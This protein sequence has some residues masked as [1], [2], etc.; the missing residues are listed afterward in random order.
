MNNKRHLLAAT[1]A[2]SLSLTGC[3]G[4]PGERSVG[5]DEREDIGTATLA[6]AKAPTDARCLRVE[7]RAPARSVTRLIDLTPGQASTFRMEGLPTGSVSVKGDA[8]N[9]A[10]QA[11]F[12]NSIPSWYSEPVTANIKVV[13]VVHL[14][15]EMIRNGR[16]SVGVDFDPENGPG[17]ENPAAELPGVGS[18]RPSFLLPTA[19][20]VQSRAILTV[21]D[22]SNLKPDGTPYRMV[23]L[24]DGLG[25]FDNGDGTFTLLANHEAGAT[26]GI[27]RA[28]GAAGSFVSAWIVRKSDLAVLNGKD[29]MTQHVMWSATTS[30]YGA[31]STGVAFSRFCSADLPDLSAFYDAVSGLGY[32]GRIFTN[33]EESG[34][35]GRAM[36]HLLNG[37]S[38]EVPRL[39]KYSFENA[40]ANP[41]TGAKTVVVGLD[42]SGNGQIYVYAGDKTNVGSPV[43]MAGLTNG[44]L[45]GL[46]VSG[47]ALENAATGIPSGTAFT[48]ANLGNVENTTGAALET[49]SVAAGATGFQRP[50]DGAWDPNNPN[51]FYFVTTASFTGNSRLWRLRFVDA[52]SPAL[53]GKI[54]MLLDGSEG[55]KM[56]DNIGIDRRG[57][58]IAQEDTGGQD[59]LGKVFRYDI[60]SDTLTTILQHDPALFTPGAPGFLTRDE[61]ASGVIDASDLLGDGWFLMSDQ[62]HRAL[63]GELIDD[64]QFVA[65]YD[66]GSL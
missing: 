6:L 21:G 49:A 41:G 62:V 42:D 59:H 5:D 50:E 28:H 25:A 30:S 54:D 56:L 37:T 47:F 36:A 33:G 45:F 40:V 2:F 39:G 27:A 9:A 61:E 66:P 63:P 57:H 23:G 18:S 53:G 14:V 64:G 19:S 3:A 44:T 35:E 12:T 52:A 65:V 31:P 11:V 48:M 32:D 43:D 34:A 58:I 60:E 13:Q 24:P 55:H 16:A 20:G 7:V 8:F 51:D 15:L 29:L 1:A 38:Y 46:S 17:N 26:A 22:T 4:M 10:C